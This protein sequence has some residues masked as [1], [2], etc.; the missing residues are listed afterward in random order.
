MIHGAGFANYPAEMF[1]GPRIGPLLGFNLGIEVGQLV[2]VAGL[3]ATAAMVGR[4]R[5]TGALAS[6]G[7]GALAIAVAATRWPVG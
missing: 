3:V 4:P 6:V 2:V 5:V 7:A 1:S